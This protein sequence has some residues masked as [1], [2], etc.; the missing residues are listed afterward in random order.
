MKI[1]K[2]VYDLLADA[3]DGVL[4]SYLLTFYPSVL[5]FQH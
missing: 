5:R 2:S 3:D 4:K 1:M